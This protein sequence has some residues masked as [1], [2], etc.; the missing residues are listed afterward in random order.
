MTHKNPYYNQCIH[1]KWIYPKRVAL[2]NSYSRVIAYCKIW[3]VN[4][5]DLKMKD[6]AIKCCV[7]LSPYVKQNCAQFKNK[8]NQS[9]LGD[10]L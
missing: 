10:F 6:D 9:Q 4:I 1:L 8:N 2:C 7:N 5:Y 3:K